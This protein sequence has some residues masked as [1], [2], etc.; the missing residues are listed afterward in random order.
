MRIWT[1][2]DAKVRFGALLDAALPEGPR[3]LTR[4]GVETA[5]V[6]PVVE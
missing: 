2:H 1:G 4:C 5:V 6:V 3:M